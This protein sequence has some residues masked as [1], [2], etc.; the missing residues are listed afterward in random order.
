M[1]TVSI[2]DVCTSSGDCVSSGYCSGGKC[3]SVPCSCGY[4]SNH[5][6]IPYECCSD[7]AC[8]AGLVCINHSC[9]KVEVSIDAPKNVYLGDTINATVSVNGNPYSSRNISITFPN[10]EIVLVTTD[11][12]GQIQLSTAFLGNYNLSVV[13]RGMVLNS[14]SVN[15][16]PKTDDDLNKKKYLFFEEEAVFGF[17]LLVLLLIAVLAYIYFR[18]LRHGKKLEFK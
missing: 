6:C 5:T 14:T 18:Y 7:D 16:L 12:Y 2:G 8:S 17:V 11:E 4:V 9:E 3:V 15:S 1:G 13:D 10:G